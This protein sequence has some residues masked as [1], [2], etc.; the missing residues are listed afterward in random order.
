MSSYGGNLGPLALL[1]KHSLLISH[2]LKWLTWSF[3]FPLYF[4]PVYAWW[5]SSFQVIPKCRSVPLGNYKSDDNFSQAPPRGSYW[6][7]RHVTL[8]RPLQSFWILLLCACPCADPTLATHWILILFI[9]IQLSLCCPIGSSKQVT[10][11]RT[12]LFLISSR[13]GAVCAHVSSPFC[14]LINVN[15]LNVAWETCGICLNSFRER[16]DYHSP[17]FMFSWLPALQLGFTSLLLS[18]NLVIWIK[19]R[20]VDEFIYIIYNRFL[21]FFDVYIGTVS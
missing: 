21:K 12:S 3:H 9:C 19:L 6:W 20:W 11:Q 18:W 8:A 17:F 10:P 14:L 2:C 1:N 5:E 15:R 16:P 7:L 4:N 13:V